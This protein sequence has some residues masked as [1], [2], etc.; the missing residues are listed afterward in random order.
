MG[1]IRAG[2]QYKDYKCVECKEMYPKNEMNKNPL[3]EDDIKEINE[4]TLLKGCKI[5]DRL[6]LDCFFSSAMDKK[7]EDK[8]CTG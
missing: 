2:V 8:K 1:L 6:C 4:H 3:S 5:G 7:D